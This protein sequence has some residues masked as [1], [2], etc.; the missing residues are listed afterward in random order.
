MR[1][2]GS[3]FEQKTLHTSEVSYGVHLVSVWGTL[4]FKEVWL[5]IE[6]QSH[7]PQRK[8]NIVIIIIIQL[9]SLSSSL[10]QYINHQNQICVCDQQKCYWVANHTMF[11]NA[12]DNDNI[13]WWE[14]CSDTVGCNYLSLPLILASSMFESWNQKNLF[15]CMSVSIQLY[16]EAL[17]IC[18]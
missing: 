4:C 1:I 3:N 13:S 11:C 5:C 7:A 12:N 17:T 14:H 6:T 8:G 10:T 15:R 16:K 18:L 2:A 9:L